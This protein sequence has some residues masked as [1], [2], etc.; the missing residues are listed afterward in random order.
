MY[1]LVV[2]LT[3]GLNGDDFLVLGL[4]HG[5]LVYSYNLGSGTATIISELLDLT[6]HIHVV[7]L[8]RFLQDGWMKVTLPLEEM[9]IKL[10]FV[11]TKLTG[12]GVVGGGFSLVPASQPNLPHKV[13]VRIKVEE[14]TYELLWCKRQDTVYNLY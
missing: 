12:G 1:P 4:R 11:S 9:L 10:F 5:R 13:A 8:G 2:I 7:S 14:P 6:R 3:P